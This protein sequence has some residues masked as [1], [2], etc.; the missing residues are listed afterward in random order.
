MSFSTMAVNARGVIQL[1]RETVES[2]RAPDRNVNAATALAGGE[3]TIV[4]LH[5]FAGTPRMMAPMRSFLRRELARPTIDL[6]LGVG[7]G[8]IRDM[9]IRVHADIARQ[10]MRRCDVIGY[11]L[12][13]LV[14]VYLAK[15]LD[16]GRCIRRVVTLGTPHNGVK[17]LTQWRWLLARWFR[18]AQQVREGSAFLEQLLRMPPPAGTAMLS[19]AGGADS[20]VPPEAA[21]I[22][23]A[24]CR[25]L[26]VPGIDHWQLPVSRRVLRCV[27][28]MLESG[29][30]SWP[31]P[32]LEA[33][34]P[35]GGTMG[36]LREAARLCF[37]SAAQRAR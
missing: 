9:A 6:A 20:V 35:S 14:A 7:F 15:C 5:G 12:G 27:K 32:R 3:D 33:V 28:E 26:V 24:D 31:V 4:L 17:F 36:G 21:R 23:G 10:G 30:D 25:N 34:A 13:G 19:I 37:L 1:A 22:D 2:W 16:Q 18:S 11:S 29:G 8:D